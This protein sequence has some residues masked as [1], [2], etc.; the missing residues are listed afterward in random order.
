[1]VFDAFNFLK[2]VSN[3]EGVSFIGTMFCFLFFFSKIPALIFRVV[4]FFAVDTRNKSLLV[5]D[6]LAMEIDNGMGVSLLSVWPFSASCLSECVIIP[7]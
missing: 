4:K 7:F 3:L 1:M 6:D 2:V 5:P